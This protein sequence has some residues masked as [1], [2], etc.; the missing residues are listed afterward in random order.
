VLVVG[1]RAIA[2]ETQRRRFAEQHR[3]VGVA[4]PMNP[5]VD[6]MAEADIMRKLVQLAVDRQR[7]GVRTGVIIQ[8]HPIIRRHLRCRQARDGLRAVVEEFQDGDARPGDGPVPGR[9]RRCVGDPSGKAWA[10]R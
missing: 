10:S 5:S 7:V 3:L 4:S 1:L 9:V 8:F 2:Q 6:A